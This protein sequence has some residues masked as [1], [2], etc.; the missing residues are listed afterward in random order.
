MDGFINL[1]K[2]GGPSS[3]GAVA[4]IK[5]LLR[6]KAGHCGALDP[7]ATGVLPICLGR[8]TRLAEYIMGREKSYLA[9]ICFGVETD[10]YDAQGLV[11]AE[12][13]AGQISGAMVEALLPRF[14]G[15]ILQRPPALSA[16][17]RGGEPLYKKQ[18]RG[19]AVEVAP[20]PVR[21]YGLRL[22]DFQPGPRP[23]ALLEIDC[24]QGAYIRSLAHDLGQA[25]GCGGHLTLLRRLRVGDFTLE[26]S[27]TLAQISGLIEAGRADFLIPMSQALAHLP[28]FQ[29][30]AETLWRVA[31]GNDISLP[32]HAYRPEP[33]LRLLG[34]DGEVLAIGHMTQGEGTL[35]KIDK[36]LVAAE[37]FDQ[38][39]PV[40]V[41]AI[42]NFD[43]LHLGHRA[44]FQVAAEKKRQWGGVSAMVTFAP[45][46]LALIKGE[47]PPMLIG[48]G[49]KQ[50]MLRESFGIDRVVTLNFDR[51]LMNSSP[52]AFVDEVVV[53]SLKARQVVVGYNFTFAAHGEGTARL[54]RRLCEERGVEVTI[55]DEVSSAYGVV[56]STHIRRALRQ[57]EMAAVNAMLGYWF[58]VAGIVVRGN[59]LGRCFGYPTANL[60]VAERQA[61]PPRGVY[62]ARVL[63]Q[64]RSYGSVVN[65]G[66]KPT[67]GGEVKPLVEA[68]LFDMEAELYG[69]EL[70]VCFGQFL[71]PERRFAHTDELISQISADSQAARA[72]LSSQ[73]ENCHLP[74]PIF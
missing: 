25:L 70:R 23:R 4:G 39:R 43:G 26:N 37:R 12:Q 22:K 17:K 51:K 47:A 58:T 64:G 66:V 45:H 59:Q 24:G 67:I 9:E 42:G 50:A 11:L 72:F 27:Y 29:P 48:D 68:H 61:M 55:V 19:E 3:Q 20:R 41:C 65:F 35:L 71:R 31:H 30:P 53:G 10:S 40:T 60:T 1:D 5:R 7:M 54:L 6:V 16:L 38:Q 2:D 74:K 56:S 15:L 46:P 18:R 57:G 33:A 21:I 36:V 52:E 44:L 14:T 73:A 34:A 28:G 69:E 63:Y 32:D 62:A 13:D 49:L 8:A